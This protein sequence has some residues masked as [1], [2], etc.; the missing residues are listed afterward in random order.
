MFAVWNDI[1]HIERPTTQPG[2]DNSDTNCALKTRINKILQI[3]SS[4]GDYE[5]VAQGVFENYPLLKLRDS[6]FESITKCLE[7][8]IFSDL[9]NK[10]IHS[11]QNYSLGSYLQYAFVVWHLVFAT[12]V[13][14][15]INYPSVGYEVSHDIMLG[16]R[17]HTFLNQKFSVLAFLR[18][19]CLTVILSIL[20]QRLIQGIPTKN[21]PF[22][23]SWKLSIFRKI[24]K[25]AQM[26]I[27][28][29]TPVGVTATPLRILNCK[30]GHVKH[31]IKGTLILFSTVYYFLY[32]LL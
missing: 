14:Q 23:S 8:F 30:W 11:L 26:S 19:L 15:K 4:F 16:Y 10:Q 29:F 24:T 12:N 7:W 25:T 5:R 28:N 20:R 18:N 13:K 6:S 22:Q 9:I 21:L 1:F 2:Q 32:F 31:K 27:Y 17:F 3:V